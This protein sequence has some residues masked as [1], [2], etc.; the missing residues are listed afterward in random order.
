MV[1]SGLD[2]QA[3]I[4]EQNPCIEDYMFD[5]VKMAEEFA[6]EGDVVCFHGCAS[7]DQ[8]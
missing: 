4:V 2:T 8:F 3:V 6:S 1:E 7:I 5:A